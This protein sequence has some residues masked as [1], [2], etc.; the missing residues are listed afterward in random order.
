M[1]NQVLQNESMSSP[2]GGVLLSCNLTPMSTPFQKEK[3]YE[4]GLFA[5]PPPSGGRGAGSLSSPPG[6]VGGLSLHSQ[7][8]TK[9]PDPMGGAGR[10]PTLAGRGGGVLGGQAFLKRRGKGQ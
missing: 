4:G 5:L 3:Q 1:E 9:V 8:P 2:Q 7:T 6:E 10:K